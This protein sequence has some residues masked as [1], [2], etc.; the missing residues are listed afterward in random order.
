MTDADTDGAYI[1]SSLL[2]FF[3]WYMPELITNGIVYKALPPLI[4][5]VEKSVRKWY[6]GSIL[7]YSR[8]EYYDVINKII[9]ANSEIAIESDA[10]KKGE[11]IVIPLKKKDYLSWLRMNSEYITELDRLHARHGCDPIIIEHLCYAALLAV[12]AK[13]KMDNKRFKKLVED[14]FPEIECD[15]TKS[16]IHGSYN[17]KDVTLVID[18]IFWKST[19]RFM[20]ILSKNESLYIH[21]KNKTDKS[22]TYTRYSIGEF[23]YT[24]DKVYAIKIDQRFKGIGEMDAAVIF[25]TTLNPKIRKLIRFNISDM[26]ETKQMFELLHSKSSKMSKK[27]RELLDNSDISYL[28]LDN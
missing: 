19:K 9:V 11:P 3:Y 16:V 15:L 13:G 21:V 4:V 6:K 28:D 27:R 10:N 12:D 8:G 17:K 18:S 23:L 1:T 22:D 2:L 20:N 14:R 24:M 26:E 7:L 5:L 25:E